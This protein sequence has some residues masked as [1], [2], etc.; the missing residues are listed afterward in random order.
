MNRQDAKTQH[1]YSDDLGVLGVLAIG[2]IR[3]R[4][5]AY[6]RTTSEAEET[7]KERAVPRRSTT[8]LVI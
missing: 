4:D 5:D 3:R 8:L 2:K 7:Q 6:D 1:R